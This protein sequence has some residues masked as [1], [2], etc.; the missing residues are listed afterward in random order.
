[1]PPAMP[2]TPDRTAVTNTVTPIAAS[3]PA[4]ILPPSTRRAQRRARAEV[5]RQRAHVALARPDQAIHRALLGDVREP[6]G[7]ARR[8]EDRR[9]ER[10][11]D[12]ER[13][14]QHGRVELDVRAEPPL[15]P[16]RV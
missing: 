13:V 4:S 9:E 15:R 16:M 6:A 10:A 12:A 7:A 11:G 2:S 1:M 5:G 3:S 14:E 8:R